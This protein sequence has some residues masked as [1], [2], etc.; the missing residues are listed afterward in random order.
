MDRQ[1]RTEVMD[2]SRPE[3]RGAGKKEDGICEDVDGRRRWSWM[4][5]ER[6]GEGEESGCVG[7]C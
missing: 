1:D 5:G 3:I 4:L 6:G 7:G 2:G